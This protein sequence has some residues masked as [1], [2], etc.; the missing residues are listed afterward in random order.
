M[1]FLKKTL[2][3][4]LILGSFSLASTFE[5]NGVKEGNN[6]VSIGL[7]SKVHN[8]N[9]ADASGKIYA[10]YGRFLTDN[11]EIFFD[12][13]LEKGQI[14]GIDHIYKDG[15]SYMVGPGINYFFLKQPTFTPYIGAQYFHSDAITDA[16]GDFEANGNKYYLGAHKFLNENT[17]ITPEVGVFLYDFIDYDNTYLNLYLTYFFN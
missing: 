11:I 3:L 1:N 12:V 15:V 17:S 7:I 5:Q 16:K 2:V 14:K 13:Y 8:N 6:R 10:Q 4:I 9:K